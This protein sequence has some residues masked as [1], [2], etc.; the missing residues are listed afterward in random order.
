MKNKKFNPRYLAFQR[1]YPIIKREMQKYDY[2]YDMSDAFDGNEYIYFD[3]V[4]VTSNG[5][6]IIAKRITDIIKNIL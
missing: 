5:N 4:H 6:L 2:M 3:H 1:I